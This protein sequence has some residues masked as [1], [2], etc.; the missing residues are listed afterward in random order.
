MISALFGNSSEPILEQDL[1]L[2]SITV[3]STIWFCIHWLF[4][5]YYLQTACLLKMT[6]Q[7]KTEEDFARVRRHKLCLLSLE[8]AVMFLLLLA[9]VFLTLKARDGES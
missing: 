9:L 2:V 4:S 7:A 6:F 5:W 8:Y 1:F 3:V